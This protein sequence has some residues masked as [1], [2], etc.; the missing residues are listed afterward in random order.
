M[1]ILI[2]DSATVVV[3]NDLDLDV[4]ERFGQVVKY[5]NI[6]REDLLKEVLD[7]DVILSNKT[8]IDGTVMEKAKKLVEIAR[9]LVKLAKLNAVNVKVQ[10]V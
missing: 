10:E 5:E 1:K 4:F 9:V 3:D 7:C 2:T 6:S 8:V